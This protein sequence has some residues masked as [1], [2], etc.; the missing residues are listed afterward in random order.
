MSFK[1]Q[2]YFKSK[3]DGIARAEKFHACLDCRYSQTKKY[4]TCPQCGS[5]NRQYFMSKAEL[6]RGMLLLTLESAGTISRL[7]FQPGFVLKVDG[8][9]IGKYV[10]DFDYYD[11]EGNYCVED[12]KGSAEH[13]DNLARWKIKHFEAQYGKKVLIT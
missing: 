8:K 4:D 10:S 7:R 3:R 5:K 13:M 11:K 6:K 1:K 9:K 2:H 12:V